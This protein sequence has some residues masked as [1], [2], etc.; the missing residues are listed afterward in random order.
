MILIQL[1]KM[2]IQQNKRSISICIC[3]QQ[4]VATNKESIWSTGRN[5]AGRDGPSKLGETPQELDLKKLV[6]KIASP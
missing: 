5:P 2:G 4:A 1:S 6:T 3:Q